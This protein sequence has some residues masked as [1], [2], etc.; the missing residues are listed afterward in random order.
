MPGAARPS[1]GD[2]HLLDL[3]AALQYETHPF[4]QR[5]ID[6]GVDQGLLA[7]AHAQARHIERTQQPRPVIGRRLFKQLDGGGDAFGRR[8]AADI[9][10]RVET[11]AGIDPQRQRVRQQEADQQHEEGSADQRVRPQPRQLHRLTSAVNM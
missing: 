11:V 8:L 5:V 9:D 4:G 6:R 2:A 10:Q 1:E 7:P 3:E